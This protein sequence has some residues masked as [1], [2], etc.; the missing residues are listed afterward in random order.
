MKRP[1]V[2]MLV[3][4][5]A[6]AILVMVVGFVTL[7]ASASVPPESQS[8]NAG[9]VTVAGN[10]QLDQMQPLFDEFSNQTGYTVE[11][12]EG[13]GQDEFLDCVANSNCP[14]VGL[15]PQP[16]LMKQLAADGT[17]AEL[18][19]FINMTVLEANYTETWIDLGKVD[20]ALYGVWPNANS[21]S[22]VWYDPAEFA[23]HGWLTATDWTEILALSFDILSDTGTP[24]WSI[25]NESGA[26][27]GWPL[28]DWFEDILLRSAGPDIY[29]QLVAHDIPWTHPEVLSALTYFGDIFG[30]QA[31]QLG[32]KS[33]TLSTWFYDAVPPLFEDPPRAY[34]H[35][36]G[37]FA[38]IW[39]DPSQ[40]PGVDYDVFAFPDIDAAY[41]NSV[42]G[43]GDLAIVFSATTE[44]QDL[45]NFLISTDA[46]EVWIAA[47]NT[48][49]N[50]SVDFDLYPDPVLRAAARQLANAD[51][52]RFDLTDQLSSELN[53]Y[54]WSQMDDLVWAAPDPDAM[55]AVM[56]RIEI[57]ARG[58][59]TIYLPMVMRGY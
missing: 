14:D 30:N 3:P 36:Q 28:T 43:A 42:M 7:H 11:Y 19:P 23:S 9:T 56:T 47:G 35:R 33:G 13:W 20:G 25:G 44:A 59:S 10:M 46:A 37:S 21:K 51:I 49:P 57:Y 31:Y 40:V 4:C 29:D 17:L 6:L 55:Q 45:I 26:A 48:S 50:R 18:T 15:V 58:A 12:W 38:S 53:Q 24:P 34:L 16:G 32:G 41:T 8:P 27:T 5:L 2:S 1:A 52:F 22:L 39:I 54:V